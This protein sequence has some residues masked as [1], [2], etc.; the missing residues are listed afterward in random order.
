VSGN[1]FGGELQPQDLF[2]GYRYAKD[3]LAGRE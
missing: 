1:T 3:K 2:F